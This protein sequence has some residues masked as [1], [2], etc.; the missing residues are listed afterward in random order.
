MTGNRYVALLRGINVGGHKKIAMARLREVMQER[1]FTDPVTY[2]Q[3]GNVVVSGPQKADERIARD[4]EKLIEDEFG[5]TVSVL[6][7]TKDELVAVIKGNPL[8]DAAREP[9]KFVVVFLSARP[10]AARLRELDHK[11]FEPDQFEVRGREVYLWCPN[12]L[13][14]S[15]FA[16]FPW[17][18]RF[19][20]TATARNWNTV[21]KLLELAGA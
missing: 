2:L 16:N 11:E 19:G 8:P 18:K 5:L 14:D 12:G 10:A 9:K 13:N 17:D 4:I 21:T 20:I 6:V 1:G 15:R 3:S 7:R